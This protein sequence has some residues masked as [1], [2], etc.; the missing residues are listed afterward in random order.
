MGAD[1]CA[2]AGRNLVRNLRPPGLCDR[3]RRTATDRNGTTGR[4]A[5]GNSRRYRPGTRHTRRS[6]CD[7]AAA[8]ETETKS[9][10]HYSEHLP[11]DSEHVHKRPRLPD[12]VA[13][14]CRRANQRRIRLP[15]RAVLWLLLLSRGH[16]YESG[17]RNPDPGD[18]GRRRPRGGQSVRKPGRVR[19]HR[20]PNRG[21]NCQQ[22]LRPHGLRFA[23][24]QCG[25]NRQGPTTGRAW[26]AAQGPAPAPICISAFPSTEPRS[27]PMRGLRR[28]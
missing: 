10:S 14:R 18:S 25:T 24:A 1:C 8:A 26:S 11:A 28:K 15:S 5:N 9:R 12:P 21:T 23:R 22:P 19:H 20:P 3:A 2:G 6:R 17:R 16:R 13:I 27:T 4:A 7:R